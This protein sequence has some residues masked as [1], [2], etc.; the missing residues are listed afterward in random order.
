SDTI[1]YSCVGY[2]RSRLVVSD[3]LKEF[4][5]AQKTQYI[6]EIHYLVED[7]IVLPGI[8]IIPYKT[9]SEI[10]TA[11]LNMPTHQ[12]I[13]STNARD[14]L[15][16]LVLRYFMENLPVDEQ[17]RHI[18][19]R[20]RYEMLYQQKNLAQVMPMLDPFA[21][22]RLLNYFGEKSRKKKEKVYDYWPE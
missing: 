12:D 15:D 1:L 19:A 20:Q 4:P 11:L 16:P 17:E 18:V 13:Y 22:Y 6:Y 14:N 7:S 9:S 5:D 2:K 8:T 21:V 3:Y 10:T